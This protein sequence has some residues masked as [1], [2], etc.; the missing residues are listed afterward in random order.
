MTGTTVARHVAAS[1]RSSTLTGV[2][3]LL[4]LAVRRDRIR[5]TAWILVLTLMMVYAP[6]A[7]KLA[8]P[9]EPQRLARVN[10]LKTP[11][12][13]MLG[14]PFFGGN[15]TDLGVMI[16]NELM[17]TLIV[18][19]SILSILTVVRH[20]R[21]E[22][23]S[24]A[25]EL[26]MSSVVGRYAVTFA[27]LV[28]VG[29]VN[30]ILA[31]TMTLALAA[32]GFDLIDC[33]A[34]CLG[35]TG[36]AMVFG[37]VAGV[38]VQ[39]WR[40]AR[41]AT[42]AAMGV[43]AAAVVVRGVGDILN[44]SGSALSWFSPI[45]WAQ[46]MRSFVDVRWWPFAL[47][48]ALTVSLLAVSMV[49]DTRREY[50]DGILPSRGDRVNAPPVRGVFALNLVLQRGQ[51]IGWGVGLFLAGLAFGSMT[52]SLQD[53]A[54]TNEL[55]AR[56][57]ATQG[58]NGIYTT[59]T[60]F[61]AAAATGFVVATIVRL[62]H[63]EESGIAE[64]V[65]AGSVSRWRWLLSNVGATL[66]GSA[67]LMFLAG[68]GNGLGAAVTMGEADL[69]PRLTA[70]GIAH[71]PAMAVIAGIAALAV[72]LRRPL[73]GWLAVTFVVLALY[74]GALLR[75]PRWLIDLSPV[76]RTTVPSNVPVTAMVVMVVVA[77]AL[78]AVAGLIYRNRDAI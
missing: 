51:V 22:E 44:H 63:D 19:A 50:D 21:A 67:V 78:T 72:A 40:Q 30:A 56:V 8:Y 71:L 33:A 41:T 28:L 25:A 46:Q 47:L 53:A 16:A 58:Y 66:V 36:A 59:L 48:V 54:Q 68:L 18:A 65:L 24:G 43:L 3:T 23:E 70:A 10:L 52:K 38:T 7:I 26:V 64:E 2:G 42:G 77:V 9:D 76:G 55:I 57:L 17:L 14:G 61:L 60:Q 20:T 62:T 29:A 27:A 4:A 11:A 31:V 49:L 75:L 73:I 39:L 1:S 32:T 74:L 35:I 5:L 45:A 34:M 69:V 6:N 15:E 12:G 13:I 37:A